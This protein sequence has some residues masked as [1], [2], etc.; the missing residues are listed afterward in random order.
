MRN[1]GAELK[2]IRLEKGISLEE[3]QKRTKLQLNI[4]KAIEGDGITDL[5]PVY[6]KGFLKIYCNLLGVDPKDYT[7]QPKEPRGQAVPAA[8]PSVLPKAEPRPQPK[9]QPQQPKS[10]SQPQ[11]KPQ[12]QPRPKLQIYE[13]FVSFLGKVVKK[14]QGLKVHLPLLK[15][16]ALTAIAVALIVFVF[17]HLG[18]FVSSQHR[19]Y[20]ARKKTQ[21]AQAA[22][23][24]ARKPVEKTA[25]KTAVKTTSKT[26]TTVPA[27]S[28]AV[29]PAAT[30]V[31]APETKAAPKESVSGIRL[32]VRARENCWIFVKVDGKVVF[33]RTLEKGRF[34][35]W[36]AKDKIEL[37]VGN[38]AS[39]E[40]EVNGQLFSNLGRKGQALKNIVITK[41]GLNILR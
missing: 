41:D 35:S 9:P 15:K 20:L 40:L 36:Q 19:A 32:G 11:P 30:P 7:A 27:T 22:K 12:S 1:P 23:P 25:P 33:Q 38:A 39:V 8:A 21:A 34:E 17:Y 14:V 26:T 13:K 18:R 24:V 3:V 29:A 6:L 5:S 31:V 2:K 37:S 28:P 16:L 4:L 10:Q